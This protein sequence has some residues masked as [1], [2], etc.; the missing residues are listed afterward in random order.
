MQKIIKKSFSLGLSILTFITPLSAYAQSPKE[1]EEL[2]QKDTPVVIEI[3]T[4]DETQAE[5]VKDFLNNSLSFLVSADS[6]AD[7]EKTYNE[8]IEELTTDNKILITWTDE[9]VTLTSKL[10]EKFTEE[11]APLFFDKSETVS[12]KY[13]N[14]EY[15]CISD[16]KKTCLAYLDPYVVVTMGLTSNST[17]EDINQVID[18]YKEKTDSENILL[19]SDYT[20]IKENF[21]SPRFLSIFTSFKDLDDSNFVN[22][23]MQQSNLYSRGFSFNKE[24]G[25]Y[26]AKITH[27]GDESE[28]KA[29]EIDYQKYQTTTY[30]YKY[31]PSENPI[32]FF[33]LNNIGDNFL[34]T[35]ESQIKTNDTEDNELLEDYEDFKNEFKFASRLDFEEDFLEILKSQTA[36]S[37]NSN[38]SFFPNAT[39]A[40]DVSERKEKAEDVI[41]KVEELMFMWLAT[42]PEESFLASETYIYTNALTEITLYP[43]KMYDED[44]LN[45]AEKELLKNEKIVITYGITDDDILLFSTNPDITD[46]YGQDDGLQKT[47]E[48]TFS[49][50]QIEEEANFLALFNIENLRNLLLTNID[51]LADNLPDDQKLAEDKVNEYKDKVNSGIGFLNMITLLS[52]SPASNI[53]NFE[54]KIFFADPEA[55]IGN[56]YAD[57]LDKNKNQ[58]LS[59]YEEKGKVQE[60]FKD[61]KPYDWFFSYLIEL[62]KLGALDHLQT[63]E[64]PDFHYAQ[65]ITRIEFLVTMMKTFNIE[66]EETTASNTQ[67]PLFT[68]V[69]T[70]E[71]YYS[72]IK[73]AVDQGII[74]G[75]DDGT[76]KPDQE[77]NRAEALKIVTKLS[78]K[79]TNF[80]LTEDST[81]PFK[82][83]EEDK[84]YYEVIAKCYLKQIVNGSAPTV[85]DPSRSIFRSEAMKIIYNIYAYE[86]GLLNGLEDYYSSLEI[87]EIML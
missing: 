23:L 25:H 67:P 55:S 21:L 37:V 61:V 12:N 24:N 1:G 43:V 73:T 50:D 42:V 80:I 7:V 5:I 9:L 27:M 86:N 78:P 35:I 15:S 13:E 57:A 52:D 79:L 54:S 48:D 84:W 66:V 30:L 19:N 6:P 2:I 29:D 70:D 20:K 49:K 22:V 31:L 40:I 62:N 56:L 65:P 26:T 33:E 69:K 74:T 87:V 58:Y 28:L 41:E 75:Y 14:I 76:F 36:L 3:N 38:D 18:L 4:E 68:D 16:T 32:L 39:L 34:N 82:D 44:D 77:I 10:S 60:K 85:F 59:D 46:I 53:V 71:W 63:E 45:E 8:L 51:K 64:D 47:L 11:L 17:E 81:I 83:V 72:M